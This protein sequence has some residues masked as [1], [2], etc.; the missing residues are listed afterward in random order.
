MPESGPRALAPIGSSEQQAKQNEAAAHLA[1]GRI[2]KGCAP[3]VRVDEAEPPRLS[4]TKFSD[5][6]RLDEAEPIDAAPSKVIADEVGHSRPTQL[7]ESR[8]A[9]SPASGASLAGLILKQMQG[10]R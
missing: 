7:A 10:P 4:V 2:G 9:T 5:L 3:V 6:A 8:R 1:L